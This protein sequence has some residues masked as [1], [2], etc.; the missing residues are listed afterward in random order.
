MIFSNY[1]DK[2]QIKNGQ[3]DSFIIDDQYAINFAYV[4]NYKLNLKLGNAIIK[5][6]SIGDAK[7]F[8]DLKVGEVYTLIIDE[9]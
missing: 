5:Q 6:K 4:G 2:F 8:T 9:D 3:I 7:M 1:K